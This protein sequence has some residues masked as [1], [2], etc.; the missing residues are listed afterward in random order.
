MSQDSFS[1]HPY[2]LKT[3][4]SKLQYNYSDYIEAWYSIFLHQSKDFSHSWFINF[5]NKFKY[6]FPYWFLHWWEKHGPVD[7]ILFV[8]VHEL[9]RH[10]TKKAKFSKVDLF[11]PKQLLFVAKYKVPWILKWSYKVTKDTRIF[12]RRFSVKWWDKFEVD[13]IAKYVYNHLPHDSIPNPASPTG[14]T[15]SSLSVEGKS[16]SELQEIARQLIIQASQMD[17]D[18]DTEN[19]S[20]SS[21]SCQPMQSPAKPKSWYEDN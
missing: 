4:Q 5:D 6:S 15:R 8:S 1:S 17:D 10:F 7:E 11:F 21:S 19:D 13:R 3:L 14:S 2:E 12:A 9:I 20:P 18:E 16:K